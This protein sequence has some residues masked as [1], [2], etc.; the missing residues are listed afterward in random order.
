MAMAKQEVIA[1]VAK[2]YKVL[3]NE[4][5]IRIVTCLMEAS[6]PISVNSICE[7]TDLEQPVVSKQLNL[8]HQYQIV[9]KEK[10]GNK[11]LYTVDDPHIVEM[12]ADMINHVKHELVG[13][14]HPKNLF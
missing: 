7:L 3:S 13:K 6:E 8:L 5:R 9:C 12:I 10:Q 1:E 2:I 11:V 14:P 4:R